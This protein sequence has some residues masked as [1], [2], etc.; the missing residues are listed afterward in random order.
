MSNLN[1]ASL[2]ITNPINITNNK[3]TDLFNISNSAPTLYNHNKND[4]NKNDFDY[5]NLNYSIFADSSESINSDFSINESKNFN[6]INTLK[7]NLKINLKWVDS[8]LITNCQ[9]CSSQ[10]GF[11]WRKHH[12]RICGGVFCSNCCIKHIIIPSHLLDVPKHEDK[13]KVKLS[14]TYRWLFNGDKQ[15]VCNICNEKVNE[16]LKVEH[17]IK[18]FYYLNLKELYIVLQISK[19]YYNAAF[20]YINKFRNINIHF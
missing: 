13:Y 10:F 5:N 16:L 8:N 7:N 15:L 11:L 19:D 6:K 9:L 4:V 17:L 18:I 12:C 14:N 1:I 2:N 20:Y 3:K